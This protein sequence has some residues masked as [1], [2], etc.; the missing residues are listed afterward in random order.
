MLKILSLYVENRWI[1]SI[2]P[3][4]YTDFQGEKAGEK[5]ANFPGIV[6]MAKRKSYD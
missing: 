6:S 5:G 3:G 1:S 2:F 4:K